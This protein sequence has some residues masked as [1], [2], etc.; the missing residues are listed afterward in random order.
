MMDLIFNER[1]VE[2]KDWATILFVVC[3]ALLAINKAVFEVRFNEFI[4][5]GISDKYIKI[6]KDSGNMQSWFTISMFFVQLI[7]FAFLI[8]IILSYYGHT[9]KT[10]W[11]SY[12]QIVTLL[13]V[14]ILSKYL[15]EKII[16]TSFNI[17]EFNEQFNL[18][19]VNYRTYIGLLILPI[20]LFLFYNNFPSKKLI[21]GVISIILIINITTYV[22]TLK[23]YQNLILGKLFYFILYLCTLEIA[24][25]Y[26]MYY[27]FTKS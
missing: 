5:L 7:S 17:E 18:Q 16:A 26:F 8:Q 13:G 21:L 11:I 12:I 2:N 1:V 3:F 9:T 27:W 19:K 6:Y 25:Y 22:F 10:N 20:N 24:P 4:R 23:I 15:I 14:F